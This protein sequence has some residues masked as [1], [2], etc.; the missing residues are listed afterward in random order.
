[1]NTPPSNN[2]LNTAG[3]PD[4]SFGTP[5]LK[6]GT[7]INTRTAGISRVLEDGSTITA[8]PY[9]EPDGPL[10]WHHQTN[11]YGRERRSIRARADGDAAT[12]NLHRHA[13]S[14]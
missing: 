7:V 13:H 2:T 14:A 11:A 8:G 1:M 5:P 12:P 9:S 10:H 6:D 3:S 4:L